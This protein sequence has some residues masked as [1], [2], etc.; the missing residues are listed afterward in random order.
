MKMFITSARLQARATDSMLQAAL[1]A[2]QH[3]ISLALVGIGP[4]D[5]VADRLLRGLEPLR[6]LARAATVSNEIDGLL[7]KRSP[8]GNCSCFRHWTPFLSKG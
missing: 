2:S 8:V 7:A 5:P 3:V 4:R 1:V 6:E